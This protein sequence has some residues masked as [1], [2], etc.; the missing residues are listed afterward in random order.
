MNKDYEQRLQSDQCRIIRDSALKL[1]FCEARFFSHRFPPHSHAYYVLGVI[2]R[3]HHW[4][5]YRGVRHD[6]PPGGMVVLEPEIEHMCEPDIGN[7]FVWRAVYPSREQ[8]REAAESLFGSRSVVTFPQV[9]IDDLVL[10]RYFNVLHWALRKKLSLLTRESLLVR[11]LTRLITCHAR[12]AHKSA[13]RKTRRTVREARA[14]L[15]ANLST[16][17]TLDQI[18]CHLGT[19]R[20]RLTR[21]FNR[22]FGLAPHT[23]LD[24]LRV[25]EAQ[26]LLAQGM[27]PAEVAPAV[28]FT[29]QSH[30]IRRFKRQ[31]GVTPG[32]YLR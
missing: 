15:E 28:G 17:L 4:V 26:R 30:L 6:I 23:Y 16:N 19:D 7:S 25:R 10:L 18:A 32:R 22:E 5:R 14:F 24:C 2:A 9:R 21:D 3:G 27:P 31:I 8:I 29:D 13:P 20:F 1:T 11:F 12:Q